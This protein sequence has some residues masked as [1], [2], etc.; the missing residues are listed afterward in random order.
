MSRP[1]SYLI[2]TTSPQSRY[3]SSW[4]YQWGNW[5]SLSN[6]P[7]VRV[8]Y[9]FINLFP[10]SKSSIPLLIYSP[11]SIKCLLPATWFF[12]ALGMERW[13]QMTE[14][15]NLITYFRGRRQTILLINK[16][17]YKA[18]SEWEMLWRRCGKVVTL[19]GVSWRSMVTLSRR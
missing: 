1:L 14:A 16:H 17:T 5:G 2:F 19:L 3:F 9:S 6:L 12:Q 18:I 7:K 10:R 11:V 8:I 13:T 15:L 4:F